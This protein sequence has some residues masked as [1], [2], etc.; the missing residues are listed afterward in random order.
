MGKRVS[1][2]RERYERLEK[3]SSARFLPMRLRSL[4]RD[5]PLT[6]ELEDLFG[7]GATLGDP[8]LRSLLLLVLHNTVTDSPW[9]VTNCTRATYNRA[10]RNLISPPDRNLDLPLSTLVR[11]SAAAPIL[12]SATDSGGV[13]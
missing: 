9:P 3:R 8:R 5:G 6:E 1:E 2:V 11:G 7:H 12:P 10:E 13:P 4:Y